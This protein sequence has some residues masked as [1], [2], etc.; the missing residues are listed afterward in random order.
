MVIQTNGILIIQSQLRLLYQTVTCQALL[1][2]TKPNIRLITVWQA[3]TCVFLS[4]HVR[5]MD[6][7]ITVVL[8]HI[9]RNSKYMRS[10]I[11]W[12]YAVLITTA[13]SCSPQLTST[14]VSFL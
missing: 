5:T 3:V 11:L 12:L 14:Y 7:I 1:P 9:L 10:Y 13:P 2:S 4:Y 6:V 8:L